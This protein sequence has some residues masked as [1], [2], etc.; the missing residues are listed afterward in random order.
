MII[1]ALLLI[2]G[3]ALLLGGGDLLVRGGSALARRRGV[4]PLAGGVSSVAFGRSAPELAVNVLAATGGQS[5]ISFGNIMGSNMA[6]I[7]LV[8]GIA[9][10]ISPVPVKL[11][12]IRR[13]IPM[14]LLATLL[15]AVAGLDEWIKSDV[16]QYDRSDGLI[17]LLLFGV[18]LYYTIAEIVDRSRGGEAFEGAETF[19]PPGGSPPSLPLSSLMTLAGVASLALGGR[20]TV[21]SGSELARGFGVSEALIGMTMIAIGTSLPELATS[22]IAAM[23]KETALAVGNII[24]SNIFNLLFVL[25]VTATIAPVRVPPG[26]ALDIA[27]VLALT[28]GVLLFSIG[29]RRLIVRRAGAVLLAVYCGY[30]AIRSF[31]LI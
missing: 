14:M 4:P 21:S 20:F 11:P 17:L 18:F 28:L 1:E 29:K 8:L 16:Q 24:G 25:G 10:L 27:V 5:E 7:G 30:L 9:A 3:L 22:V 26:G 31:V 12:L 2:V 23:R 15:A 6:N 19:A 13:E